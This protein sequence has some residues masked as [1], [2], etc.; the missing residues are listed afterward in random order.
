MKFIFSFF[1]AFSLMF[2]CAVEA[3]NLEAYPKRL[4]GLEGLPKDCSV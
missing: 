1:V 4:L 3:A 2:G